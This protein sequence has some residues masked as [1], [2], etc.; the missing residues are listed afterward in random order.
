MLSA[1]V[2]I[3]VVDCALGSI[4][5]IL[6]ASQPPNALHTSSPY[7]SAYGAGGFRSVRPLIEC[8]AGYALTGL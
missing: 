4:L 7:K 6:S 5:Q 1:A 3:S 2:D 8:V